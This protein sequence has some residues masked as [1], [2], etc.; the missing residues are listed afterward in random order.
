MTTLSR[1]A[2]IAVDRSN[3]SVVATPIS[4]AQRQQ[5]FAG[6]ALRAA[7]MF[8]FGMAVSGQLVFAAYVVGFYGR[9]TLQGHPER[10]NQV[11][12]HGYVAALRFSISCLRC[13]CCLSWLSASAECCS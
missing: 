9:V 1:A 5:R 7:A 10:W 3:A 11:M 4:N 13:T 2:A 8:W 6:A 12:P